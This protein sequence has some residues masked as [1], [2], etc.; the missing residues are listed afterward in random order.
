MIG[1]F[2]QNLPIQSKQVSLIKES[3]NITPI[4]E[5][6]CILTDSQ[7]DIEECKKCSSQC[8]KYKEYVNL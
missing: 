8:I 1:F 5:L 3:P 4:I 2:L 6:R 7:F